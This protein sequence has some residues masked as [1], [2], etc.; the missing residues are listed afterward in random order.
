MT[1]DGVTLLV[2]AADPAS[3]NFGVG[4][5]K[6]PLLSEHLPLKRRQS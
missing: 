1:L 5:A 4:Q 2:V 6:V 3:E